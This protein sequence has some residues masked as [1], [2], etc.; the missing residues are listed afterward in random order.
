[1]RAPLPSISPFDSA[2]IRQLELCPSSHIL[3]ILVIL[4]IL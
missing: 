3:V 1:M 2:E 4:V